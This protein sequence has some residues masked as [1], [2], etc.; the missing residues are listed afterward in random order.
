MSGFLV[1]PAV[2][3]RGGKCV[4]LYQGMASEETVFSEDPVE[5]ALRWEQQGARLIHVV[6]LDG[7][8]S[9]EPVNSAIIKKIAGECR[10]P[11]E[12]GGGVRDVQSAR[13]YLDSGV[14]RVIVGTVALEDPGLFSLMADELGDSLVVGIDVKEGTVALSGWTADGAM[15]PA[16]AVRM[17]TSKGAKRLIYTDT[18]KDGTLTGPNFKG[19]EEMARVAQVPVIA[20]GG[21]GELQHITRIA[22]LSGLGIEGV[23]VGMALYRNKFTLEEAMEVASAKGDP[24]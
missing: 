9:G 14:E 10:V 7:A 12:V 2:D 5:T 15:V 17:V 21:V 20:S 18:A 8:F 13:A 3:I 16:E 11:I 19:I 6:D 24:A 23:I 22:R 1:I 4:R